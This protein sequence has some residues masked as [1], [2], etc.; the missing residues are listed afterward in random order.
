[1]LFFLLI[2]PKNL[3]KKWNKTYCFNFVHWFELH[4]LINKSPLNEDIGWT[5]IDGYR[6]ALEYG[7]FDINFDG[8]TRETIEKINDVQPLSRL[9]EERRDVKF[10]NKWIIVPNKLTITELEPINGII[11]RYY[12]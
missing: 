3:I 12:E 5:N 1:M 4:R 10:N 6:I 11:I 9:V 2:F 8:F 7:K